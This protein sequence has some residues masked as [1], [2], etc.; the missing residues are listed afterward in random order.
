[1]TDKGASARFQC[2]RFVSK[3]WWKTHVISENYN[4]LPEE[5]QCLLYTCI[6][7]L[8]CASASEVPSPDDRFSLQFKCY[9]CDAES[10]DS[11]RSTSPVGPEL[12][13]VF[14]VLARLIN[15]PRIQKHRRPR[16]AAMLALKRLLSHTSNIDYLDLATSPFGQWCLQA[17]H[18][19]IRELRVAAGSVNIFLLLSPRLIVR[20][21]TLPIFLQNV[22]DTEISLRN[23]KVALDVL[24][25]LSEQSDL[26]LQETCVLAWGQ[27]ARYGLHT[28]PASRMLIPCSVSLVEMK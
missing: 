11:S 15:M 3:L 19:S 17:L 25:K 4:K 12:E 22:A 14:S 28:H 5:Q 8:A 21:R 27:I 16:V 1:M 13:E 23:R 9:N 2:K 24:R 20:R 7:N 26:A 6:G 10:R 18:S